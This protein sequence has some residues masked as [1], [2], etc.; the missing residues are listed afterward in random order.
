MHV[1]S[2]RLSQPSLVTNDRNNWKSSKEVISTEIQSDAS[3]GTSSKA[4]AMG[5]GDT[6][7]D[8]DRERF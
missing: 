3:T 7:S 8:S 2:N 1:D 4:Q 6:T 5:K